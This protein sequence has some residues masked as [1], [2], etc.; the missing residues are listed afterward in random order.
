MEVAQ[1]AMELGLLE[2]FDHSSA[3]GDVIMWV[4]CFFGVTIMVL[5]MRGRLHK[6]SAEG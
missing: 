6:S 5:H 3:N 2:V 4:A 1:E